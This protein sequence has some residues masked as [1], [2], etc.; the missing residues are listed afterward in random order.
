VIGTAASGN[1]ANRYAGAGVD[2]LTPDHSIL[3][4]LLGPGGYDNGRSNKATDPMLV[5]VYANGN[6]K[7]SPYIPGFTTMIDTAA[8]SDEG[9]NFIDIR[10]G[11]LTLWNCLA[12]DGSVRTPQSA[13]NCPLFGDYHL[14]T[15]SP[16]IDAG[17]A[18]SG[19]NGVPS[20][21]FDGDARPGGP[22]P[23]IGADE[24]AAAAVPFVPPALPLLDNFNRADSNTLG[25]GWQQLAVFG[26]AGLRAQHAQGLGL[27]GGNA[28]WSAAFGPRQGA[29][30]TFPGTVVNGTSLLLKASGN[31]V[32]GNYVNFVRVRY[33]GGQV[34]VDTTTNGG[35]GYANQR[36]AATGVG[37]AAGD[38]LGATCDAAGTVTVWKTAAGG[39]VTVLGQASLP[40]TG[41]TAFVAGSGR[42]GIQL[43]VGAS[44]DDF[45]AAT[46]P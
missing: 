45:R 11:P 4:D 41:T 8:T 12:P 20:V 31:F 30:V 32:L 5:S 2:K 26:S 7:P 38:S 23:D 44:V 22:A 19:S 42:T 14:R 21:D 37:F 1:F 40:V 43:P 9:G 34:L 13:A 24:L 6:R 33:S 16:A 3:S 15:G 36:T 18:A 39:T 46:V 25:A 29:A 17:L 27:V 28:Y 35:L 10:Y